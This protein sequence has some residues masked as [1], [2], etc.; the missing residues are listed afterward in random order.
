MN[1]F[2]NDT[3]D[4][5]QKSK[6]KSTTR[7]NGSGNRDAYHIISNPSI[8]EEAI[9]LLIRA[10]QE[11]RIW[12]KE[13]R[14]KTLRLEAVGFL[15][16][17]S[18]EFTW[19]SSCEGRNQ[20]HIGSTHRR[21]ACGQGYQRHIKSKIRRLRA[22]SHDTSFAQRQ[23]GGIRHQQPTRFVVRSTKR[24]LF[25]RAKSQGPS[26]TFIPF[27]MAKSDPVAFG[28]LISTR[29]ILKTSG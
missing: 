6:I 10:A 2:P 12:L 26:G 1:D 14:Y 19:K 8:A 23:R 15:A 22:S 17:C 16:D 9:H 25:D 4:F 5:F 18:T 21:R 20:K 7:T 27:S 24:L 3:L 28:R 29:D 13:H 11:G